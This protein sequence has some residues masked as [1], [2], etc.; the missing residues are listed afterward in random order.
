V[1]APSDKDKTQA[2]EVE[3]ICK[4]ILQPMVKADGGDLYLV[5]VTTEDVHIHLSGACAGCPGAQ[6][7]RDRMMEPLIVHAAPKA[8]LTLTTGFRVPEGARKI[9]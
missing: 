3:R 8:K 6:M 5:N 2:D 1:A 7:T 9:E 4:E